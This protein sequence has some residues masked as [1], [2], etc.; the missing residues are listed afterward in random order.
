MSLA[1]RGVERHSSAFSELSLTNKLAGQTIVTGLAFSLDS[2]VAF[3]ATA[4]A[5]LYRTPA[6]FVDE[7]WSPLERFAATLSLRLD[8]HSRYEWLFSQRLSVLFDLPSQW[9]LRGSLGSGSFAPTPFMD[10]TQELT[11]TEIV[12]SRGLV[13]ERAVNAVVDLD[14]KVGPLGLQVIG[15]ATRI[16]NPVGLDSAAVFLVALANVPQPTRIVGGAVVTRYA[17]GPLQLIWQVDLTNTSELNVWTRAR[18][19][20]P[21]IPTDR[22][23]LTA[24]LES[25]GYI[26]VSATV[27][28]VGEQALDR[29]PY[30]Q[31]SKP[32][33]ELSASISKRV[34]RHSIF[35]SGEDL[36]DVRQSRYTPLQSAP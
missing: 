36:A 4:H 25:E 9:I 15:H 21:Y 2:L 8:D 10:A 22:E 26:R 33:T 3:G 28:R 17:R 14:T 18:Q 29:D 11:L 31:V 5:Y 12:P 13:V 24:A 6:A 30:R 19:R 34:G 32:Y 23:Q 16:R 20:L 1:T 35:L 27:R 7:T